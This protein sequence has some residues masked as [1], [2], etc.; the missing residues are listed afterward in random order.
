MARGSLVRVRAWARSMRT[1]RASW[2]CLHAL[3]HGQEMNLKSNSGMF[4]GGG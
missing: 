1:L 4:N 2:I 3:R